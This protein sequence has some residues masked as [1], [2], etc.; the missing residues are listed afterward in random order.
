MTLT[1]DMILVVDDDENQREL[2]ALQLS[3]LGRDRV[4]LASCAQ[5][6]LA[7]VALHGRTIGVIITDL[8]MPGMDGTVLL[9]HLAQLGFEGGIILLSGVSEEILNSAAGLARAHGLNVIGVL[10]KPTTLERTR[11]L[12]ARTARSSVNSGATGDAQCLTPERL[13]A[14]LNAGEIVPWYQPKVDIRSG[15]TAGVEALARW[16]NAAG[17]VAGPGQFVPAMEAAGLADDLFFT[18]TGRAL[19]DAAR[20]RAQ[21][22]N[23][24]TALNM[25]MD[26]THNLDVPERLLAMACSAG[27]QAGDLV[28]EVT[29]SR[30]M[31]ERTLAMETLTR[32]SM[33]GFVLSIDDFGT[34]YSSLVQLIDLPFKELKIDASFVQRAGTEHKAGAVLRTAITIGANLGMEVIAEGVETLAQLEF[35]R[36]CGGSIVQG[37]HFARPM[38]F[39]QCTEW[40]Q[41]N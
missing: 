29:E 7:Q 3:L 13:A 9:R 11:A 30:L 33:M 41:R 28:I 15:A 8:S 40:L 2:M 16:H 37:Y 36:S 22:L 14:A 39:A 23:I 10:P 12:L 31:V 27:L 20:W 38:P 32:L 17:P 24:K 34:G 5:D 18:M 35:L 4:Q 6:A 26:T 21:G 1:A 25:S 19:A